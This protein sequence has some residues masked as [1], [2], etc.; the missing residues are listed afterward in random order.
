MKRFT[1]PIVALFS[2]VALGGSVLVAMQYGPIQLSGNLVAVASGNIWNSLPEGFTAADAENGLL[3][4]IIPRV[5]NHQLVACCLYSDY[6]DNPNKYDVVSFPLGPSLQTKFATNSN[7]DPTLKE[8]PLC[9]PNQY[10][11]IYGVASGMATITPSGIM[12]NNTTGNINT[13]ARCVN[14]PATTTKQIDDYTSIT[15]AT[16]TPSSDPYCPPKTNVPLLGHPGVTRTEYDQNCIVGEASRITNYV[17]PWR[18]LTGNLGE[19][20]SFMSFGTTVTYRAGSNIPIVTSRASLAN[21][22]G[23]KRVGPSGNASNY[24]LDSITLE[25]ARTLQ[26]S[27]TTD[28]MS[29][30]RLF[31]FS[32]SFG[33]TTAE[34]L[35]EIWIKDHPY[36]F[37]DGSLI[38]KSTGH[39]SAIRTL[40]LPEKLYPKGDWTNPGFKS[41]FHN[42]QLSADGTNK[43]VNVYRCL[44][45]NFVSN[46]PEWQSHLWSA[47][48]YLRLKHLVK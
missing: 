11:D 32:G 2:V 48:A 38:D 15:W 46:F 6:V 22:L 17:T 3:G 10:F 25:A 42:Y 27:T 24:C 40:I 8:V 35:L 39:N 19:L 28:L 29:N 37:W 16:T 31:V 1:L 20:M 7:G 44:D 33:L 34:D 36:W 45:T 23:I 43:G 41:L 47:M 30:S 4:K 14:V 18:S 5:V 21:K 26:L 13:T 12:K 9:G